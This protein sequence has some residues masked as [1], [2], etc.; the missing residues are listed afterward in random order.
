[1]SVEVQ[2]SIDLLADEAFRSDEKLGR[3]AELAEG[4]CTMILNYL[5]NRLSNT[6]P[7]QSHTDDTMT[8]DPST[9]F[10]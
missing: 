7:Q 9:D 2:R 4:I 6:E 1:M 3:V 5:Q 8:V 10:G